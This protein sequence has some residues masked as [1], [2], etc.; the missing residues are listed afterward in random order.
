MLRLKNIKKEGNVI[1]ALYSPENSGWWGKI[2]IDFVTGKVLSCEWH[3]VYRESYVG[4][5][6]Q[7]LREMARTNDDRTEALVMWS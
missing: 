6:R 3:D 1:S 2:S 5:A 4:H 7:K